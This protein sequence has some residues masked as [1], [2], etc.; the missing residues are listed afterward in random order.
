MT[1]PKERRATPEDPLRV[2]VL[3]SGSGGNLQALL[4]RQA[5]SSYRVVVVVANVAGAFALTRAEKAGVAAVVEGHKGLS[6]EEHEARVQG[7][8]EEHRVELVVLAGY[9]RVLS[10]WLVS[11]WARRIV[12]VHPAILPA[13]PGMHGAKQALDHGCRIAGCTVHLVDD[14]VDTGPILLQAAVPIF[15]GDDEASLQAR[16]Q[17]EEHRLLPDAVEAFAAGRVV[18]VDGRIRVRSG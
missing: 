13:F 1:P 7:H 3:V 14:G 5:G 16:I 12:N 11:R 2:A 17:I 10:S 9:M 8:L 18:D 15:D 4:D 6:R